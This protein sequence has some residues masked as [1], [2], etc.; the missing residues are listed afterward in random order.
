MALSPN[1]RSVTI[2]PAKPPRSMIRVTSSQRFRPER[3][4]SPA[5]SPPSLTVEKT[6]APQTIE[7]DPREEDPLL[8]KSVTQSAG[9]QG[10]GRERQEFGVQHPLEIEWRQAHVSATR[11]VNPLG[12]C[13]IPNASRLVPQAR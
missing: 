6:R 7:C 4:V 11:A 13:P 2:R 9:Y 5:P 8:S 1:G 3:F 10:H 12:A